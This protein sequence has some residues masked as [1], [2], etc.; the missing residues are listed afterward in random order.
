MGGSFFSVGRREGGREGGREGRREREE[1][2]DGRWE[3]GF[4]NVM[5][6]FRDSE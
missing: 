4:Q 2:G 3:G 5:I 6:S 1:M